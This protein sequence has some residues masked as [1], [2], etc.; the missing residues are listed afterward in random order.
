MK[1]PSCGEDD[2]TVD[3]TDAK[4]DDSVVRWRKCNVCKYSWLTDEKV[5]PPLKPK[6]GER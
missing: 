5:R 4:I 6:G 1:C 2:H 3:G